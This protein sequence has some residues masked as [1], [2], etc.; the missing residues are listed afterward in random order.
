MHGLF[1]VDDIKLNTVDSLDI[2]IGVTSG[3]GDQSQVDVIHFNVRIPINLI[4][5]IFTGHAADSAWY[6]EWSINN[7]TWDGNE[8][9]T[10]APCR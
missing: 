3:Y 4:K 2:T 10:K 9:N 8:Y 1:L 7:P 5:P 6:K